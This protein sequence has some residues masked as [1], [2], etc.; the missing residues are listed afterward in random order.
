[1]NCGTTIIIDMLKIKITLISDINKQNCLGSANSLFTLAV[2]VH[3]AIAIITPANIK[4]TTSLKRQSR[5]IAI[6]KAARF[7]QL[8]NFKALIF[9][10]S[11]F[12]CKRH[13]A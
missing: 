3:N 8:E 4:M 5:K 9:L 2:S 1:M 10:N 6:I 7:S 12:H 11:P 13:N